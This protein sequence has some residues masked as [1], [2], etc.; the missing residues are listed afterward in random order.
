MNKEDILKVLLAATLSA[1]IK[2]LIEA[3][4]PSK[5]AIKVFIKKALYITLGYLLPLG[6]LLNLFFGNSVIDKAF[7]FQVVLFSLSLISNFLIELIDRIHSKQ[8]AQEEQIL[9]SFKLVISGLTELHQKHIDLTRD[10]IGYAKEIH[11]KISE[12]IEG[13]Q[14]RV[15]TIEGAVKNK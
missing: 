14:N 2:P 4:M 7:V 6:M 11:G 15:K 12:S 8:K 9:E 10:N 1:I 5:D 13:L 3:Y